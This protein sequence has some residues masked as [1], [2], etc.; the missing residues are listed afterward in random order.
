MRQALRVAIDLYGSRGWSTP[1]GLYADTYRAQLARG[2]ELGLVPL[3]ASFGPALLDRAILDAVGRAEG[4]SFAETIRRNAAGIA[5]PRLISR[6]TLRA[7]I[8]RDSW[9][10]CRPGRDIAVRHTVGLVDPIVASDQ[11]P[12]E[13]VDDGLPE[14]LAE[15]VRHYGG[16]YYKLKVGGDVAAD[17]DRLQQD[18]RSA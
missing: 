17:L 15:V 2:A 13:R 14:T 6:R 9:A 10:R 11:K 3:V 4:L 5:C 8:S 18:R 12:G 16:R 1:F 7:S